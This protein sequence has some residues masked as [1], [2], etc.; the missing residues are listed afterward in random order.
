MIGGYP[1][2]IYMQPQARSMKNS[3]QIQLI[4]HGEA[5]FLAGR[6]QVIRERAKRRGQFRA[7]RFNPDQIRDG[8]VPDAVAAFLEYILTQADFAQ[9]E[10]LSGRVLLVPEHR[11][12]A[13]TGASN[14]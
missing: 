1:H 5:D 8:K 14:D 7:E 12:N 4:E 9:I 10:T 2:I 3:S 11:I 6:R 13:L